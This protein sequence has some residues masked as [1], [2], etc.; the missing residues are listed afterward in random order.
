MGTG[1]RKTSVARVRLRAGSGTIT[2][3]ERPFEEYFLVDQDRRAVMDVL[4]AVGKRSAVD[5]RIRVTGGGM[6]GQAGACRMGVARAL[7]SFDAELFPPL[8]SGGFLTRDSREKE[9]KKPG[10]KRAR[11]APQYTKR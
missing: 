1:R 7:I 6:T 5:I 10:L 9:R 3:N 4:D 2:I 8:R 11:K